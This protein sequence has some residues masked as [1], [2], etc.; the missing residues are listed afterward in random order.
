MLTIKKKKNI[1]FV[2]GC[3]SHVGG[4]FSSAA[5]PPPGLQHP[6]PLQTPHQNVQA[7]LRQHGAFGY[8]ELSNT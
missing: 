5:A 4:M 8:S 1:L 7:V 2:L 6:L 3:D